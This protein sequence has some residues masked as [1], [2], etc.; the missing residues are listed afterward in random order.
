MMKGEKVIDEN[1]NIYNINKKKNAKNK[2]FVE[3]YK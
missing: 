3:K 1:R 2:N